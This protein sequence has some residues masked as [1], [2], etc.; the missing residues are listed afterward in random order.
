VQPA[1]Q[2]RILLA[3]VHAELNLQNGKLQ[4]G[5]AGGGGEGE[6]GEVEDRDKSQWLTNS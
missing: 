1:L 6:G 4:I 2:R 5:G 3:L